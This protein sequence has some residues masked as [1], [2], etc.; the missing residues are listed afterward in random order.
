MMLSYKYTDTSPRS[1][2]GDLLFIEYLGVPVHSMVHDA[3]P[4]ERQVE[5]LV[6]GIGTGEFIGGSKNA[7]MTAI[8]V[9]LKHRCWA[10]APAGIYQDNMPSFTYDL[11]RQQL[12]TRGDSA[13]RDR[14]QAKGRT[15]EAWRFPQ[16][17]T[18]REIISAL[19]FLGFEVVAKRL[20]Y[21][22]RLAEEDK[23][24]PTMQIESLQSMAQLVLSER[25][26]SEPRIGL[27]AD[28]H[29][30]TE[31]RL[32]DGGILAMWFLSDGKVEFAGAGERVRKGF[33]QERVSGILKREE[34]MRAIEPFVKRI[35]FHEG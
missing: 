15:F 24:E 27:T 2:Q 33:K 1:A 34:M 10:H 20:D 19:K 22:Q 6:R 7:I 12:G 32:R 9:Y 26:L 13:W 31:W 11:H 29:V 23:D 5:S 18:Q 17:A 14:N 35:P 3:P 4:N 21:L 28:G 25:R 8:S 16:R 30:Q